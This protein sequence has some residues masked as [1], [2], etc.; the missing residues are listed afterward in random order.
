MNDIVKINLKGT[1]FESNLVLLNEITEKKDVRLTLKQAEELVLHQNRVLVDCGRIQFYDLILEKI[2]LNF[3]DS[4]FI[5]KYNY[6][7]TLCLMV[8][9]FYNIKNETENLIGDDE[10]ISFMRKVFDEKANGSV[11][12][13]E[14]I[15]LQG[16]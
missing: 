15:I 6:F 14:D 16:V 7:D 5:D 13:M 12:Y 3:Y 11:S 8:E 9:S 4:V 10:L 2:L 1:S